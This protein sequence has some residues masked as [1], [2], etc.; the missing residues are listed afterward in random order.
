M[1]Y[2]SCLVPFL[3]RLPHDE[4]L[5]MACEDGRSFL[6]ECPNA[7]AASS[8]RKMVDTLEKNLGFSKES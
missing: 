5:T 6:E 1:F 2:Q 8:F 3:G 4:Q 7:V